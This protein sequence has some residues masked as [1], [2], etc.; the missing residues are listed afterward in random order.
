MIFGHKKTLDLLNE[1]YDKTIQE[2]EFHETI[3]KGKRNMADTICKL[4][5]INIDIINHEKEISAIDDELNLQC[6]L[7]QETLERR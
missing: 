1:L 3:A 2:A 5:S 4:I 6:D 7:I